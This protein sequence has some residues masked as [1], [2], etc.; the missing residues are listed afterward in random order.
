[1]SESLTITTTEMHT[2]GEPLRIVETGLPEVKGETLLEKRRFIREHMDHIRKLLIFEPRGH[3]DMYGVIL[4][5]SEKPEADV[6]TIFIHNEGYST[7]CGHAIIALGRYVIDHKMV[8]N[9]TSPETRVC[10]HCP[11]GLVE[12]YVEY[13][14]GKTGN[15][16]FHS[17]PAFLYLKDYDVE[18]PGFGKITVD[19]S[20]GGAFYALV[21]AEKVGL[22]IRKSLIQDVIEAADA[23]SGALKKVVKLEHPESKDLAFLYGTILTDG[24]DE[25]LEEESRNICVFADREVDRSPCG[26]GVT[27]RVA[28]QFFRGQI[29]MNQRR[30]FS[31]PTGSVF[32]GQAVKEVTYGGREAV[33]VEVSGKGHY[34]GTAT[35]TL[36]P[37]DAIEE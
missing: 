4:V 19:I 32:R 16:R 17:V 27:A 28:Q 23:I 10:F 15:V 24:K 25:L 21:S 6:G 11:C 36:E 9:V 18:V 8:K 7:M 34:S 30:T 29:K 14:N 26:S 37:D 22:D 3:F 35:Y 2:G 1:M 12:A 33:V 5:Q 31:G 20:Y 13:N